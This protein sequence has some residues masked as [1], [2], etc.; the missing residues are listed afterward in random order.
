MI[1]WTIR[2]EFV[3]KKTYTLFSLVQRQVV[4]ILKLNKPSSRLAV[5]VRRSRTNLIQI[6]ISLKTGT[7][8]LF[9]G[10]PSESS[11]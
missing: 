8:T 9:A 10:E 3:K 6:L 11:S 4:T 2:L 5:R 7:R 1:D